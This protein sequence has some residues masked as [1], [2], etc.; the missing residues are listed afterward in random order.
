MDILVFRRMAERGKRIRENSIR[1]FEAW[2]ADRVEDLIHYIRQMS[3]D[4]EE[5][6]KELASL[7][8]AIAVGTLEE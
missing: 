6:A 1:A 7:E 4:A 3:T 8:E 5:A 2:N